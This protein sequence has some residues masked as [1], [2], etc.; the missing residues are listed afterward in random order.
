MVGSNGELLFAL[1]EERLNRQKNSDAYPVFAIETATNQFERFDAFYE[2]WNVSRRLLSKGLVH[3]MKYGLREPYYLKHRF[4]HELS[5]ASYFYLIARTKAVCVGHH[6]AHAYS[7]LAWGLPAH[8][9]VLVSDA[10]GE[11]VCMSTY[12]WNG[13]TMNKLWSSPYPNS[14]GGMYHQL[15]YHLGFGGRQGPG[16]LMALSA[17][18][19]PKWVGELRRTILYTANSFQII[20]YPV[21]RI[22]NAWTLYAKLLERNGDSDASFLVTEILESAG[23]WRKGTD[24]AASM[25]MLFT[26]V[27]EKIVRDQTY[28]LRRVGTAPVAI[29]LAGGCALNCQTNGSLRRSIEELGLDKMVVPPWPDDSGT[30]VGAATKAFISN[31]TPNP[32]EVRKSQPF[33]AGVD[34]PILSNHDIDLAARSLAND[35][36]IALCV[37]KMEFGPRALGARCI[38]AKPTIALK[39]RLNN[40]KRRDYF[41]PFAPVVLEKDYSRYFY[42]TGSTNMAWTVLARPIAAEVAP[43]AVHISGEARVQ[44]LKR[45]NNITILGRILNRYREYTGNSLL[46]LTS[47]NNSGEPIPFKESEALDV[48]VKLKLDAIVTSRGFQNLS[49]DAWREEYAI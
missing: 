11:D 23:N 9:L 10:L 30:A 22:R 38:L 20:Q 49:R 33:L 31:A 19:K 29:G 3:S 44:V 37:G 7:L 15:A 40:C 17:Y 21:W 34:A 36:A 27:T 41:M 4:L 43:G 32:I 25:Q 8:S 35:A 16:K 12:F 42:G 6:E 26:E 14:I 45:S 24:L 47:L 28:Q 1:E 13:R 18:G 5:R 46:L 2:G 48:A 39:K